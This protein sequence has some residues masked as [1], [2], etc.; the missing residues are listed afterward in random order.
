[1]KHIVQLFILVLIIFSAAGCHGESLSYNPTL[2]VAESLMETQPDSA[3]SVL[4]GV[5][6]TSLK[7]DSDKALFSLLKVQA[8]D[9]NKITLI[10]SK[11]VT[12]AAAFYSKGTDVYH[13][14]L[15]YYYLA[16]AQESSGEYSLSIVNLLKA[17]DLR[18]DRDS[19]LLNAL[20]FKSLSAVY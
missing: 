19:S 7:S 20:I 1:M 12:D 15:S 17:S 3:L 8:Y 9:R 14:K 10:D 13:R 18:P 16:C 2:L 6:S 11:L 4:S 5:D